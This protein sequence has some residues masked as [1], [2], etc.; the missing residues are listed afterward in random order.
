MANYCLALVYLNM[1]AGEAPQWV[2]PA[3][4]VL[5][6]QKAVEL[7][8]EDEDAKQ[9]ARAALAAFEKAKPPE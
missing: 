1:P 3:K 4:A 7:Q 5:H 9:V 6:A 8:P 2:F